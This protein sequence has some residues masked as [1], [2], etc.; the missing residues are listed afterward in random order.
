MKQ[1]STKEIRQLFFDYFHELS[2]AVVDS[3]NL[4][5][6]D[7][8]TLL[9]TNAGM[10]QFKDVFLGLEKREYNRAVTSQKCLRVSGKH[11]DLE[12]VGPSPRH[13]TFFEMLGNFSFGDYFKK[14][15]IQFAWHLLVEE[16]GLP[17]DRL[18]FT[19][20]T[21]D[22]EAEQLWRQVGAAPE[23]VLRFGKKDNWWAMGDIGPCGPCSEI[24]FYWGDLDKQVAGGVNK[25]DEYLEIWNLVFMQYEQ[26]VAGGELIPLPRPSVDTGAGLERLASILQGKD[27]NYDTDAFTPIMARIQQLL[28]HSDNQRREHL[29]GYRVIADHSRAMTFLI[30][31]GV[32]PGNESRNYVLRM[33][34]RRA[35][36]YGKRIG[37][38][39]PFLAAVCQAVID[40]YGEHYRD[41]PAKRSF[42][43][44]T[45]TAEEERFQ[46]TLNTGLALLDEIIQRLR[47]AGQTVIPGDEAFRLWG[48]YGFPVDITRDVAQ[49]QGFAVDEA[50]FRAALAE[51]RARS[52]ASAIAHLP[53]D[54][55]VYGQLL[56]ELQEK[57]SLD[58]N[59]VKSLIYESAADADTKVIGLVV[60]GVSVANAQAGQRVEIVLPE[61]PFYVESGGQ[62]SD[63]G[64]IYYF[65][66]DMDEA[67]WAVRVDDTRRPIAGMIVHI[68]EVISGTVQVGDPAYA[69]IDTERRWDVMRNHTATHILH[70]E[71]RAHLGEHVYQAGSL[72]APDRLR[73][74]FTHTKAISQEELADIE[75]AANAAILAN[76]LVGDRWSGLEQAKAEGAMA[77]FS[78]KYGDSVRVVSIGNA[79]DDDYSK[80]LCGGTHVD[81]TA[82]IGSLRIISE[83]SNAA[84]VRRIEAVTG[85]GAAALVEKRLAVLDQTAALL[86]VHP[87]EVGD[88][89][90]HLREQN[91][92]LQQEIEQL[93]GKLARLESQSLLG[94]AQRVDGLAVL[95]QRVQADNVDTLRQMADWFRDKLGSSVVVL[96]AVIDDKPMLIAAA[97]ED[98]VQRGIHAGNLVRDAAKIVGGNGGGRPNM[99]QAGGRDVEKLAEALGIVP[100]WVERNLKG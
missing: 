48:T 37:F 90:G 8:P 87:E 93:Q 63:T 33:V 29:T 85:R 2:H 82:E 95:A 1:L 47:A 54:L 43:L 20:Y 28:G 36:R 39:K 10:V 64:D 38:E 30:G 77:L 46:R 14:E 18:W 6:A 91:R 61:T 76:F 88:A 59:G 73:F 35:A 40:E 100:A 44:Q 70:K 3:S 51:D 19:V 79:E 99:A 7:D 31:D 12:N 5:P 41:L 81:S 34:L 60:D 84:G 62:V 9:F 94:S 32:L 75:R 56:Q 22:D 13:H 78:E 16:M 15:A 65:P 42:I 74:D 23:R 49:E 72:V 4:V 98:A 86:R 24:H 96:G 55:S 80:E 52:K 69:V 53:A 97:T 92:H 89:V 17:T 11:N 71:L 66:E 67:V 57:G 25:D 26:K 27:N 45:V 50:G 68:G 58:E 83:G 21:D